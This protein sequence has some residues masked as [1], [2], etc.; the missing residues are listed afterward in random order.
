MADTRILSPGVFTREKDLS[1][2]P[3]EIQAIGAAVVG[4]TVRG[5]AFAPTTLSTYEE[6]IRTFGGSFIS[7][8][9]TAATEYKYLTNYAAQM[10]LKWA[11][12]LTVVR[13]LNAG[14]AEA[15]SN[16]ITTG[17]YATV[18]NDTGSD[19]F[20]TGSE[21][22]VVGDA[23]A[24]F[25]L[26]LLSPGLYG[27]TGR[28]FA[29]TNGVGAPMDEKSAGVLGSGSRESIRW[30][31]NDINK[32]RGTFDLFIR[33]GDDRTNRRV[34][35]EQFN[36]VS[37]DPNDS[38]YLPRV[39]GDQRQ[40][41]R[42]DSNGVPFLQMSGS[43]PNR[44]RYVRVE[45]FKKTLDY[46]D[47]EG[48]VRIPAF[49]ASL[50]AA[51]SGTFAFGSDGVVKHP[52]AFYDQIQVA[53]TQGFDLDTGANAASGSTAYTDAIEI[54]SNQDE[55]DINMLLLPGIIDGAGGQHGDVYTSA[56]NMAEA[57]GDVF[58]LV[59]PTR[60]GDSIAQA[61]NAAIG[62]N[63]SY[64]AMYYPWVQVSDPDLGRYVW[65]PPS[66]AMA[67]VIAF[68]DYVKHPW[69][70]PAGL[71]RGGVEDATQAER[72][73]TNADRDRLYRNNVNPIATFPREG[74]VVYGQKTLQ[75]K[76]SAL[77]RVN[78]RRLLIA[79]KKYIASSSRYLLFEQNTRETR[80][81]FLS[82]V[83]PFLEDIRRKQGL[84]DFRVIMDES[85]NTPDVIDRNELRGAIYL[86][87]TRTVEYIILDF[88]VLPTGAVFPGD[89]P[90]EEG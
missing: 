70:A 47:T 2:L 45:I 39:V 24:A 23:E 7:G 48:N 37:L 85:N 89:G 51:V 50:P 83:E 41:L 53:N 42:Y 66:V 49:S 65:L 59:D 68:N 11:E 90:V 61:I 34:I 21:A 86:K 81:K 15:Y 54:L 13:I 78:V 38:N 25:K 88:F 16:V 44:S 52:I 14:Y 69:Y 77:D 17:S 64:A 12:N 87:P 8:S 35:L 36:D 84:Y 20:N 29:A 30:E 58:V 76:R 10:Y 55:Y 73:L 1:F 62:R 27:N 19:A 40:T 22:A 82:I 4:P 18:V 46:L 33:R 3:E 74:V 60:Y 75:K 43:H 56:I 79:A 71:N 72:K 9:G 80:I 67:G 31:I 57:R 6:F 5:R 26:H 28:E 32:E 63:S